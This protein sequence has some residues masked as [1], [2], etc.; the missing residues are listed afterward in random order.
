MTFITGICQFHCKNEHKQVKWKE[1]KQ[2]MF[3]S[4]SIFPYLQR[5]ALFKWLSEFIYWYGLSQTWMI[6]VMN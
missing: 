5:G 3:K 6:T 1:I 2:D 4:D